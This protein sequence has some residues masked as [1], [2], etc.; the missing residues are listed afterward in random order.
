VRSEDVMVVKILMLLFGSVTPTGFIGRN[1]LFL[2]AG[3]K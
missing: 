2:P 1:I 3:L